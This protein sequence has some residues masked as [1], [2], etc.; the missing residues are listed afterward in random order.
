MTRIIFPAWALVAWGLTM[1]LVSQLLGG[2]FEQGRSCK[3][4]CVWALYWVAFVITVTGCAAG[5]W[6]F[7]KNNGAKL[8]LVFV[9]VGAMFVLLMIFLTTMFIG[10]FT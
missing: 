2:T 8:P 9:S 10:E 1:I 3:S 4:D 7:L 5:V 6:Q